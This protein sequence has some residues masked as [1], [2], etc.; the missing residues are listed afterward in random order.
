MPA[1]FDM[2]KGNRMKT[3]IL[4]LGWIF[5]LV[6][7]SLLTAYPANAQ[8]QE[9]PPD[10]RGFW[11]EP[12]NPSI[13]DVT[14]FGLYGFAPPE[15]QCEWDFGDGS[16]NRF[17]QCWDVQ[18][19]QYNQDGDYS[20][21]VLVTNTTGEQAWFGRTISVRTHDVAITKFTV[22][23]SASAGQTRQI[24]VNVR[25]TRYPE[26]VQVELYKNDM[27]WI[28]TLIQDIPARP[29]N[30]TTSYAFKY[31]FT[32][33]DARIGKV[34]FRAMAFIL[35]NGG[36]DWQVDNDITALPTRVSR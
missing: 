9:W 20:V 18:Y 6:I 26:R 5:C 28:G 19:K 10:S 4:H 2:K 14:A 1:Q 27:V 22:P 3:K 23:Q 15:W 16:P 7:G 8:Y 35:D 31:T 32:S 29:A 13:F 17:T 34:T 36:D 12:A 25:N 30:R 33:E 11:N 21:A 24:V